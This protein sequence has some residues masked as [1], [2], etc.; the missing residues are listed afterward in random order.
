MDPAI[1]PPP[2]P[3]KADRGRNGPQSPELSA[4]PPEELFEMAS[5]LASDLDV[6]LLT[7]PVTS[8]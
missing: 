2:K 3:T 6:K 8:T 4:A 5:D 1:L 7:W